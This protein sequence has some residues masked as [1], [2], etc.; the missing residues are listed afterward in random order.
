MLLVCLSLMAPFR[1]GLIHLLLF[2]LATVLSGFAVYLA[3]EAGVFLSMVELDGFAGISGGI[4]YLQGFLLANIATHRGAY[5]EKFLITFMIFIAVNLVVPALLQNTAGQVAHLAGLLLGLA[6]GS[7]F[8][9][10]GRLPERQSSP[11]N[12][13]VF[14]SR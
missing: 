12:A 1:P 14:S 2:Y 13:S 10:A 5:P 7:F 6:T 4:F 9:P 11:R 8:R 3:R